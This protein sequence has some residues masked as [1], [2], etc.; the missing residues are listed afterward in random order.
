[1]FEQLYSIQKFSKLVG[2]TPQTL[3]NWERTGKVVP[4]KKSAN[5]Y[6]YYSELQRLQLLGKPP[7]RRISIGYCRVD[8]QSQEEELKKQIE[9]V[10]TFMISRGYEFEIIT[11]IGSD[12][13]YKKDGLEALLTKIMAG[14][15]ENIVVM[16][17]E[18]LMKFGFELLE[19]IAQ[20]FE[21]NIIVVDKTE[22]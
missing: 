1:M 12:T 18:V 6:R 13:D 21:T 17:R 16:Q 22:V 8:T 5:G 19:S 10:K 11:D 2:V 14:D 9:Y 3:R 15:V 7:T 20:R 4:I